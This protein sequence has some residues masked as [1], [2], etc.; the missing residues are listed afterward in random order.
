MGAFQVIPKKQLSKLPGAEELKKKLGVDRTGRVQNYVTD[1]IFARLIDYIPLKSGR[2]RLSAKK[3]SSTEI[4]V[5]GGVPYARAQ[6]FGVTKSGRPF[7]YAPTGAKVGAHWDRRLTQNEGAQIVAD[8][9]KY[10]KGL[11]HG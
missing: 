5:G 10:V 6:F 7:D 4:A 8:A 3:Q 9:N 11:K 1:D 2:L